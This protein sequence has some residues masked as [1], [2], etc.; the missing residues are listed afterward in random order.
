LSAPH[1][2]SPSLEKQLVLEP[3]SGL[4]LLAPHNIS[5]SLEKQLV[6]ELEAWIAVDEAGDILLDPM[7]RAQQ[8]ASAV[9]WACPETPKQVIEQRWLVLVAVPYP[10]HQAWRILVNVCRL[11]A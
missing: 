11:L 5:P 1:K 2:I 3:W 4:V 6:L 7:G 8:L 10:T 9:R